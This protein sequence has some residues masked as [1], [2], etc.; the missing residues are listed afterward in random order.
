MMMTKLTKAGRKGRLC[1]TAIAVAATIPFMV[2]APVQQA[3]ATEILYVVNDTPVTSYDVARRTALLKLMRRSGNLQ[4]VATE[5]MINQ[6]LRQQEMARNR[7]TITN[8]MVNQSYASFA[9]SNNMSTAQL[10]EILGQ[11]GVTKD[12]FKEFIRTQMGW[13]RV[14]QAQGRSTVQLSQQDVVQKLLEQGGQKPSA[15]EYMLQQ[16]IFVV[17]AS[18]RSQLLGKRKR[19]A[20]AMRDRFNGCETTLEFAKGLIDVTVRD[21]GRTLAPELP[22]D[23]KDHVV[24]LQPGQATPVRETDRGVE[25]IGVCSAREVSDDHVA[26][27]LFQNEQ[28]EDKPMEQISEELTAEL[29]ENAR[30]VKR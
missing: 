27:L 9:S 26:K 6:V 16:V 21:L 8:E 14:L 12:H 17:P 25:F 1:L 23:W 3:A 11:S 29:R 13:G 28:A 19:E 30:I 5:E 15:T 20:Q 10:D 7:V 4:Q 24:K 18:E 2:M 22:A